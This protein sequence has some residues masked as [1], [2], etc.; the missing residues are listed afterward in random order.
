M[1]SVI[2][3]LIA[4]FLII[5][6]IDN[7]INYL[8]NTYTTRK[9]KDVVGFHIQKYQN[10]MDELQENNEKEKAQYIRKLNEAE[11]PS[12]PTEKKD[13]DENDIRNMNE[14]L[15]AFIQRQVNI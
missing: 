12:P 3:T 9:T 5:F 4:S 13:L 11:T 14:D 6:I 10:I 7:L 2:K 15:T 8:K 1:Y